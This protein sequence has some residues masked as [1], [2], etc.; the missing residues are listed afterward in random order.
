MPQMYLR[1]FAEHRGR[2]QHELT[3]RRT[4]SIDAPFPAMTGN[5]LAERGYYWGTTLEGAPHHAVEELFSQLEARAKPVFDAMLDAPEGALPQRWPLTAD[6]RLRLAWWMAAQVLRTTRQRKRLMFDDGSAEEVAQVPADIAAIAAN[7]PHLRY[8]AEHLAALA[9]VLFAR[10][11]G[12]GFSDMCLLTSDVPLVML[13][14]HDAGNQLAAVEVCDILL[15]LDPHRFLFLPGHGMQEQ[16]PLKR[17]DH[18]MKF[19]GG[20]GMALVQIVY[21]VADAFVL[22][23]P[24]HDPWRHW[25]PDGPRQPAPWD[26][27]DHPAPMYAMDYEV[28]AP[29]LTVERR[30]LDEHAPPAPRSASKS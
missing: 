12:L 7:N 5:I 4:A 10:P 2:R 21:D 25:K 22:H 29:H 30:W 26:G 20:L 11:W 16:D 23:H 14:G 18:R 6:E 1:R 24:R 28:L 15:P 3:V 27:D 9:L 13:N 17:S 8:I 19:H